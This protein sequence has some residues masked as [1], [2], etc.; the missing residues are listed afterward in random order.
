[1]SVLLSLT[2]LEAAE[3]VVPERELC[4]QRLKPHSKQCSYRNAEALR[5]PKSR[6]TPSFSATALAA[7]AMSRMMRDRIVKDAKV[8]T[9]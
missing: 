9:Q 5:H 7:E 3:K 6:A 4:P 8:T 2:A 1:V